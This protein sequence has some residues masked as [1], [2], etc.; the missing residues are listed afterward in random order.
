MEGASIT[1]N[2]FQEPIRIVLVGSERVPRAGLRML[3]DSQPGLRVIGEV[4]CPGPPRVEWTGEQPQIALIDLDGY[5]SLDSVPVLR[6]GGNAS[7]RV[8]ILTSTPDSAICSSAIQH[9]ALGVVS[10]QQA[11]EVLIEAIEKVHA[12]EVWLERARL[13]CV[14]GD[15]FGAVTAARRQPEIGKNAT[16]AKRERQV[17]TLV[18]QGFRNGEIAASLFVS[19]AT[20]RNCLASIFRKLGTSSRVHLMIYALREGFVNLPVSGG[21]PTPRSP[22]DFLRLAPSAGRPLKERP[23]AC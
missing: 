18:A 12:G 1:A 8:I 2:R 6:E 20:V 14:L 13:A 16:L 21:P 10:K 5:A 4:D 23:P 7:T 17:I 3:I 19:E 9:G 15:L 11:P 22:R